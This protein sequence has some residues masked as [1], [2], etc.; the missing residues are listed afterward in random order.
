MTDTMSAKHLSR[1]KLLKGGVVAAGAA[2]M[3]FE[4]LFGYREVFGRAAGD[5]AKTVLDLATTSETL[6]TT[7][8]YNVLTT[9]TIPLTP[10]EI[11]RLKSFLDAELQHLA[12]LNANG[13][14]TLATEFYFPRNVY[15]DR[16]QFADITEQSEAAFVAAYLSAVRRF[17]E[18]GNPLLAAT[19]AQVVVTEQVHLALVREIGGRKP[20]NVSLAQALV[21][22]T[23]DAVPILKPF[24]EGGADREGPSKFPGKDAIRTLIGDV[25]VALVKPFTDP[26]VFTQAPIVGSIEGC[27]VTPANK[28]N[29]NIRASPGITFKIQGVLPIGKSAAVDSKTLDSNGFTWYHLRAGGYVRSDVVR[30]TPNCNNLAVTR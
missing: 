30:A 7:H 3:N 11:L 19:A 17:T 20:N 21:Y 13:G 27:S 5:D 1:R 14:R 25:G 4:Q 29:V 28:F 15:V 22:N 10:D 8:Y 26:S 18:L 16:A 2:F 24:L 6:A 9:S 12:Y 23:S